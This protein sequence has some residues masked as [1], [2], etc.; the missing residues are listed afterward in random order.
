[1]LV[2]S[3]CLLLPGKLV[4]LTPTPPSTRHVKP[5]V[6]LTHEDN[7]HRTQS[8][9]EST[10]RQSSGPFESLIQ[11]LEI[12]NCSEQVEAQKFDQVLFTQTGVA[13]TVCRLGVGQGPEADMSTPQLR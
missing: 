4:E 7:H 13:G 9:Q 11:L 8:Y 3:L 6:V 5:T 1:M 2:S 10:G 12:V